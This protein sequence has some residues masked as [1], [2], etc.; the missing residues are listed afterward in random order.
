LLFVYSQDSICGSWERG[1]HHD[2]YIEMRMVIFW[3][4]AGTSLKGQG[5]E[6]TLILAAAKE[7]RECRNRMPRSLQ[8]VCMFIF[9]CDCGHGT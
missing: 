6:G 2:A 9:V 8:V 1:L 5:G 3:C 4:Q 7:G